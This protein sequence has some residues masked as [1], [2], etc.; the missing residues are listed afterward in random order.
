[1]AEHDT[2]P[3]TR[4]GV[5]VGFDT[6][7]A[8]SLGYGTYIGDRI[9]RFDVEC[10]PKQLLG[11]LTREIIEHNANP[12]IKLDTG[13]TVWGAEC[14]WMSEEDYRKATTEIRHE[15]VSLGPLRERRM[16]ARGQLNYDTLVSV[17][18]F[19]INFNPEEPPFFVD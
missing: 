2:K 1:M 17:E 6:A 4:V 18:A 7:A 15:T 12:L 19:R 11:P 14:I 10:S 8:Y 3:G 9:P 16:I 13:E 5:T